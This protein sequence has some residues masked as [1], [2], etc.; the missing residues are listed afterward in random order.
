MIQPLRAAHRKVFAV[1]A[2]ALPM[3]LWVG[4]Q[5]RELPLGQSSAIVAMP[6]SMYL[7]RQSDRLW[8]KHMIQSKFYGDSASGDV[9]VVLLPPL[10][11]ND[12]DLLLYWSG[13]LRPAEDRHSNR[14][15]NLGHSTLAAAAKQLRHR[16]LRSPHRIWTGS[17]ACPT[18]GLTA[19]PDTC[20]T[21]SRQLLNS[22]PAAVH[23]SEARPTTPS[24]KRSQARR[25]LSGARPLVAE[26][27]VWIPFRWRLDVTN[28]ATEKHGPEGG[29]SGQNQQ[30]QSNSRSSG[31]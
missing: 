2:I 13:D 9:E 15:V 23:A 22:D 26:S 29:D 25:I 21:A 11:L 16:R 30:A 1:L 19:L 7:V 20:S 5:K 6:S 12:P 8:G 4:L 14:A 18:N 27:S 28:P 10:E 31:F 3:V 17:C 24:A